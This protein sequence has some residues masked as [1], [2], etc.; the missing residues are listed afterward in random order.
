MVGAGGRGADAAGRAG[1]LASVGQP[2]AVAGL[3]RPGR[4]DAARRRH[5]RG[6]RRGVVEPPLQAPQGTY[7]Y[8][9]IT[10][11]LSPKQ[12]FSL[13]DTSMIRRVPPLLLAGSQRVH[14]ARPVRQPHGMYECMQ[15]MQPRS[16]CT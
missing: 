13:V 16:L 11:Q 4:P 14:A 9:C 1:L 7:Q 5:H 15:K 8:Q 12:Y 3:L 10:P 2:A 6:Q